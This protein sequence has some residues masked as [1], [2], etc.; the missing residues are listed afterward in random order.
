M[1]DIGNEDFPKCPA[2]NHFMNLHT[3]EMNQK[4]NGNL[5]CR[6]VI[7]VSDDGMTKEECGCIHTVK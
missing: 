5:C 7:R 3:V 6:Y 1:S 4:D 2:C